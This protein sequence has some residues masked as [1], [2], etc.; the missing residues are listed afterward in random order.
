MNN[1]S[2]TSA[3]E[4]N[5]SG[6]PDGELTAILFPILKWWLGIIEKDTTWKKKRAREKLTICSRQKKKKMYQYKLNDCCTEG[7]C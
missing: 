2:F 1:I 7:I 6:T 4:G 3:V 5:Q